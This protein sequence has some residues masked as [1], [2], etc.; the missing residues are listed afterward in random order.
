M[1]FHRNY[2]RP[3]MSNS[4]LTAFQQKLVGTVQP[5]LAHLRGLNRLLKK[6][7]LG[8]FVHIRRH[9]P[10]TVEMQNTGDSRTHSEILPVSNMC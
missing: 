7:L 8:H 10:V 9:G 2:S 3:E 1:R 6:W 4:T 5:R